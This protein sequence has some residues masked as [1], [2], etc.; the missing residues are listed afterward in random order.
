MV[1]HNFKQRRDIKF[2]NGQTGTM[3]MTGTDAYLFAP[4]SSLKQ[5]QTEPTLLADIQSAPINGS[6]SLIKNIESKSS[7][8]KITVLRLDNIHKGIFIKN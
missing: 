7:S 3:F 1:K 6:F 5:K 2:A 4:I 8:G